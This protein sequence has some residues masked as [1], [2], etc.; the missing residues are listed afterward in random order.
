LE[1]FRNDVAKGGN[2]VVCHYLYESTVGYLPQ[3]LEIAKQS[4]KRLMR[5]DQCM[6]DP[7]APPAVGWIGLPFGM[8]F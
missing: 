6:E 1:N 4:G 5:V 8:A 7:D 2:L 3:F